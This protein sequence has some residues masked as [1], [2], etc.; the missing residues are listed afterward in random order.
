MICP[1]KCAEGAKKALEQLLDFDG[2]ADQYDGRIEL[3]FREVPYFLVQR[4]Q[5]KWIPGNQD[6]D[7]NVISVV[8]ANERGLVAE[9]HE[10]PSNEETTP[11]VKRVL[12]PWANIISISTIYTSTTTGGS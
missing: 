8:C 2:S 1:A 6:D 3:E 12:I 5:K 9:D 7:V 10:N 11:R 4:S